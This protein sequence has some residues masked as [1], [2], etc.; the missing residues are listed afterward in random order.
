MGPC[1]LALLAVAF[2]GQNGEQNGLHLVCHFYYARE[3][4]FQSR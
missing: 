3:N 2:C 4:S 1:L